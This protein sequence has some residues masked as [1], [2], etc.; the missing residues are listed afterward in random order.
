[1]KHAANGEGITSLPS[2]NIDMMIKACLNITWDSLLAG[3]LE[4]DILEEEDNPGWDIH[5]A[6]H[7]Q[8][9]RMLAEQGRKEHIQLEVAQPDQ[10]GTSAA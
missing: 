5:M 6:V 9:V 1:M 8:A 10:C 4:E 2:Q 7:M 3:S